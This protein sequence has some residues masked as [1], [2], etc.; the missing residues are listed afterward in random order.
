MELHK[1]NSFLDKR[2]LCGRDNFDVL[3]T[4]V[5][6]HVTC[7]HCIKRKIGENNELYG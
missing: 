2:T 7:K 4:T 1:V 5:W 3:S 6:D